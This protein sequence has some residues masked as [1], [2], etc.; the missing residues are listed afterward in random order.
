L[1]S[2]KEGGFKRVERAKRKE[3]EL[4]QIG[5]TTSST[6]GAVP[7]VPVDS[8]PSLELSL[9]CALLDLVAQLRLRPPS[10]WGHTTWDKVCR[11]RG[12]GALRHRHAAGQVRVKGPRDRLGGEG[13]RSGACIHVCI[14]VEAT[15]VLEHRTVFDDARVGRAGSD[16][17]R[18][19]IAVPAVHEVGVQPEASRV[20]IC[21]NKTSTVV[22]IVEWRHAEVHFVEDR[23]KVD[24]MRRRTTAIIDTIRVSHVRLVVRRVEVDTIPASR[25]EYLSPETVWAIGVSESWGLIHHRA[26]EV[27]ANGSLVLEL[28]IIRE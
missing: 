11:G 22:Q 12:T 4:H 15:F 10:S 17:A 13:V 8:A 24:R 1:D 28:V 14:R 2:G 16:G 9:G 5:A 23:D 18:E 19:H 27:K 20:A 6:Q 3:S 7:A 25:E 26:I 21:E